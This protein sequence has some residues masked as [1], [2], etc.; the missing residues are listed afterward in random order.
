LTGEKLPA[1][2]ALVEEQ[3]NSKHIEPTHTPFKI[4]IFVITK[5]SGR[6]RLL[7]DLRNV[8]RVK[9]PIGTIQPGLPSPTAISSDYCLCILDFKDSFLFFAILLHPKDRKICFHFII[10][11]SSGPWAPISFYSTTPRHD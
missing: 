9:Q 2:T 7:Q 11:K 3:L 8:N 6:G 4:S 5:K 10:T 1:A